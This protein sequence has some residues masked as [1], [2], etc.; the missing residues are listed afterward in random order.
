MAFSLHPAN[1][2]VALISRM[3]VNAYLVQKLHV[4][5]G[6][7]KYDGTLVGGDDVV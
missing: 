1:Q 7:T 3:T 6:R 4:V 5:L 2:T